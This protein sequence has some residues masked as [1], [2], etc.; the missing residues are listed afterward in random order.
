MKKKN[1]RAMVAYYSDILFNT[2]RNI[3]MAH[4]IPLDNKLQKLVVGIDPVQDLHGYDYP[5]P[6]GGGKNKFDKST[7]ETGK[8]LNSGGN[9]SGSSGWNVSDYIAVDSDTL[10]TLSGVTNS[11][12]SAYHV[13]YDSNRDLVSTV[14]CTTYAL[15]TP[16]TAKFVRLSIKDGY[17]DTAQFETGAATSYAPYS[18]ICPITGRSSVN[19]IVSTSTNPL[20]GTITNIP[21]G[22]T[23]YGGQLD[24]LT[25]VLKVDRAYALLNDPDLWIGISSGVLEFRYEYAFVNRKLYNDS[26]SGL[27]CSFIKVDANAQTNTARWSGA[28]TYYFGLNLRSF[29]SITLADIKQAASDG[30]IAICYKLATSTTIQLT[31][32]QIN[33]IVGSWNYIWCDSGKIIEIEG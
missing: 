32:Q 11:G 10:Y 9:I 5:W 16:S 3:D 2:F 31:P 33:T 18:N 7:V 6:E 4:F 23:V 21:L 12:S 8:Y 1:K 13:F 19:V 30:K 27:I 20:D 17:L 15:T 28:T 24:A 29:P 14:V 25:G 26:Y 22:Q